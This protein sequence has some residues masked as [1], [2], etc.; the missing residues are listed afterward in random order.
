[1]D[2]EL[3]EPAVITK[4][5]KSWKNCPKHSDLNADYLEAQDS[6]DTF[7]AKLLRWEL[8]RE[9]GAVPKVAK[10]KSA[11]R[12]KLVRKQN[13][14]KYPAL[15][16]PFLNTVDMFD[17]NP[18]TAEDVEAAK[19]NKL[20]INYQWST[21]VNKTKLVGDIVRTIVDE[22]T[23]I[24]KTGWDSQTGVKIVEKEEPVY[25]N[26]EE[27]LAMMQEAVQAGA[28]SEEQ[29][30][31]M[32]EM[33]EPM[34]KGTQKVYVEEETLVVNQPTYE[35]CNNANVIIDPTCEGVIENANFVIHEYDTDYATLKRDAYT[36]DE[37]G[38]SYGVYHNI[39]SIEVSSADS[40]DEYESES[41]ATFKFSD[42]PRKKVRAY[43]YWGYWDIQGDGELV[44]IVATWIGSV[45]VRLEE[46]PFPH[47]RIPFSVATYMPVKKEVHGEPDAEILIENQ[48]AIGKMQ[49]AMH[50]ITA[51]QAVGQEFI[52][53]NLFPSPSQKQAYE[54]GNTVYTRSGM[55]AKSHIHKGTVDA[56]PAV[57][58]DSIGYWTNDAENITGTRPFASSNATTA[59]G[60]RTATDAASKRE[61][62]ILRRISN[63]LF[64]DMA[65]MTIAMNQTFLSEEEY[66][67]I[68]ND[69]FV[70]VR[71]DDLA[72]EFDLSI[73]V[74]TPEKDD[75]K[76]QK[77]MTLLQ[78][79]QA[80]MDLDLQKIF[81]GQLLD[82]WKLPRASKVIKEFEP[83]PDEGAIQLQQLQ[84]ENQRLINEQLKMN[85]LGEA[86]KIAER[87]S[88]ASENTFDSMVKEAKANLAKAQAAKL[89]SET[90]ILDAS[91][92]DTSNNGKRNR[93]KEDNEFKS[94]VEIEKIKV[95][96]EEE[97]KKQTLQHMQSAQR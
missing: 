70:A 46:N 15:A 43:E 57:V 4:L 7:K 87:D 93:E 27:S 17:I 23:V 83:K 47:G 18:R 54:R 97:R 26:P 65:R 9:G 95:K 28:M 66:I 81:Y 36:E 33:G 21:K 38:E 40:Y 76:A 88:R 50:D 61:L 41:K 5:Q 31:A 19:S 75:D 63:L 29:A 2:D 39:E 71:R 35:V 77:L 80:N 85:M 22:G 72:G 51:K 52:D 24:V 68:T 11:A 45:M 94:L 1:M 60:V 37:D 78:T 82:L 34:Q 10:G 14:W 69:E 6:Q 90:D 32:L 25:A 73:E 74:S 42:K 13:E 49:R 67:R 16:E 59:T 44:S 79:N 30:Q 86:S 8:A 62:D 92:I 12:P 64:K 84:I 48:D 89:E 3:E 91:Y 55:S 96:G 53:E 20:V 56:V 58:F